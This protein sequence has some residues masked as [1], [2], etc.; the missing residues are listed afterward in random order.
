MIKGA[1]RRDLELLVAEIEH[2]EAGRPAEQRFDVGSLRRALWPD[3]P[4]SG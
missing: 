4:G 3:E 2:H 1:R